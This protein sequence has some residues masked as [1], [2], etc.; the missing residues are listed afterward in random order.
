MKRF[1]LFLFVLVIVAGA[2]GAWWMYE[3]IHAPFKG[4]AATEQFVD[5]PSGASNHTIANRLVDAG[6]VRDHLTFR[7]AIQISGERRKLKA[8]EYRFDRAMTPLEVVDKIARGDVYV[9]TVTFPE[10]LNIVEMARVF[11]SHGFGAAASFVEA[12]RDVKPIHDLDPAATD[13]EGYLFPETYSVPRK[14]DAPKLIHLMVAQFLKAFTPEMRAQVAARHLMVGS[15]VTLASIVEKETAKADERPLVAAVYA[16]RLR[17]GML[18][19]CDPTVIYALER[20]GRYHGNI[21]K[22][23]LQIDSPYN[24]YRFPGLPPGP[25]ASPGRASL[26]AAV[27]PAD[28][29]FLYFVSRNDGSHEF[30]KTLAEH[31]RNVQKFQIQYFR[32]K[33]RAERSQ[34]SK[35]GSQKSEVR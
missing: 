15:V 23:D 27:N 28:A 3:Q 17:V 4:Y 2:V 29:Y 14:T 31:N 9:V 25:I 35:V 16:N 5:I 10:G 20:A 24:T 13:L 12:A 18:L 32:E 30:A 19:Q 21:H 6:V 8:G 22:D 26:G 34:N 11:E 1:F 7:A 33:R